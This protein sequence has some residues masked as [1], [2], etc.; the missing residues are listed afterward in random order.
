MNLIFDAKFVH[1]GDAMDG[2]IL[3]VSFDTIPESQHE[4]ERTTPYVLISCNF[5]FSDSATI[6]WHDGNDYNGGA[7]I[8]VL[9]LSRTSISIKLDSGLDID[10]TFRLPDKEFAQLTSFLRRMID[11]DCICF[12]D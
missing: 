8:V 12:V 3:Q 2:E 11:D 6:E 5:E 10:I 1:C 4:D 9:T 7:E